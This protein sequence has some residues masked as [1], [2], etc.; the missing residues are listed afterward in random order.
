MRKPQRQRGGVRLQFTAVKQIVAE[1]GGELVRHP[2]R[3]RSYQI[4]T[5]IG[6]QK[7]PRTH[8]KFRPMRVLDWYS[9]QEAVLWAEEQKQ[10]QASDREQPSLEAY[11]IRSNVVPF[12]PKQQRGTNLPITAIQKGDL[13]RLTN[14]LAE[15]LRLTSR[16]QRCSTSRCFTFTAVDRSGNCQRSFHEATRWDIVDTLPCTAL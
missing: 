15:P 4:L 14:T 7:R 2:T 16:P 1:A 11:P 8:M 3:T 13:V 5:E 9:L 12:A 10:I 6:G